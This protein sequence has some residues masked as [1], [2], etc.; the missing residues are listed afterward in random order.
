MKGLFVDTAGWVACADAA[1][2]AHRRSAAA[3]DRWLEVGGVLVTS[4]YIAD[5]TL[6]F[7]RLRLG[8]AAAEAWWRLV[9]G[10]P[11]L[12]WEF[13]SLARAD[14]ARNLFFRYHDKDFSFTDCTSFV[15]MRDLKLREA[16]TTDH[17]FAQAGFT[18]LPH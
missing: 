3:R 9:D 13:V 17:H 4:D 1:D 14:K 2:P 11:R 6:T 8:L 12:R 7:L 10:S 5:E 18:V 16:L 15:V